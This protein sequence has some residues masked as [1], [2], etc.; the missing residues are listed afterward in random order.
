M[1]PQS[2]DTYTNLK[3]NLNL[4]RLKVRNELVFRSSRLNAE[5]FRQNCSFPLIICFPIFELDSLI[6]HLHLYSF[7]QIPM[8]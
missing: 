1:D 6:L 7:G 2:G 4:M 8:S 3:Q 5:W